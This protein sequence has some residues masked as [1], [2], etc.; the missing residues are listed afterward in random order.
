MTCLCWILAYMRLE[1]WCK[2]G[3][4]AD[5]CLCTRSGACCYW[6]R[7]CVFWTFLI[8]P[9]HPCCSGQRAIKRSEL[10][11][12]LSFCVF[13]PEYIDITADTSH[14]WT[15]SLRIAQLISV[16]LAPYQKLSPNPQN[17]NRVSSV[18]SVWSVY[19]AQY[20]VVLCCVDS[21]RLVDSSAL[22]KAIETVYV[23]YLPKN[24][25]PFVYLRYL[26]FSWLPRPL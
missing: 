14:S 17:Q 2:S 19:H 4:S 3:L 25:H 9:A 18:L 20:E 26:S 6:I 5:W 24:T 13:A 21:D 22:R 12:F 10:L 1:I 8:V 23:T 11:R 16:L 15:P 7:L